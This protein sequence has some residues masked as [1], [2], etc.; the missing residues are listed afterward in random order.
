MEETGIQSNSS[1]FN[2]FCNLIS[3]VVRSMDSEVTFPGLLCY[4]LMVW[5]WRASA[6][7]SLR[8]KDLDIITELKFFSFSW[9]H[10]WVSE[11][12]NL[13]FLR[14]NAVI[15]LKKDLMLVQERKFKLIQSQ[16]LPYLYIAIWFPGVQVTRHNIKSDLKISPVSK[17][18]K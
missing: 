10:L 2:I 18:I 16:Q 13:S 8:S 1:R 5:P 12:H 4:F 6:R 17:N 11:I 9:D 15:L 14:D 3:K 7:S